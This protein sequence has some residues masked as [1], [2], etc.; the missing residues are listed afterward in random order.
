MPV[1]LIHYSQ[2]MESVIDPMMK[3]WNEWIQEQNIPG[4]YFIETISSSQNKPYSQ[5]SQA[6]VEHEP[7]YSLKNNI[8]IRTLSMVI[9][10]AVNRFWKSVFQRGL[11]VNTVSYNA[12]WENLL[13]KEVR[14]QKQYA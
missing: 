4:I 9:E 7:L 11:F 13:K 14:A 2:H 10:F 5:Y 3:K 6:V 12:V 1:F 8:T